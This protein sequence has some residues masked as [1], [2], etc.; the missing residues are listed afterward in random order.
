MGLVI[1]PRSLVGHLAIQVVHRAFAAALTLLPP[2]YVEKTAVW[3]TEGPVTVKLLLVPF[4]LVDPAVREVT[5]TLMNLVRS[6]LTLPTH[7]IS[8]FNRPVPVAR[9]IP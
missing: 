2:P 3:C 4:A 9:P 7:S 1:G 8:E 6:E 5:D